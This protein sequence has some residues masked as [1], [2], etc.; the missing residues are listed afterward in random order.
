MPAPSRHWSDPFAG[1][2]ARLDERV[3]DYR[4]RA[5][6]RSFGS[7]GERVRLRMPVVVYDPHH[8]SV[9]SDVDIGEFV[10]LRASGGLVIGSR[11]LVAASAVVTTRG[12]RL[13][14]PRWMTVE[15]GPVVIEDDVW[16][17]AGA[18]VLPGVTL[19]KGSVVAAGAVVTKSV[20]SFTV[21][22]G[23]PAGIL[24]NVPKLPMEPYATPIHFTR[25]ARAALDESP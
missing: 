18:T 15:D 14:H 1:A 9:G 2:V 8:L 21:V 7:V 20:P 16:V 17:G 11:V 22:G 6:L 25:D 5:L 10:V 3:Q 24:G 19:G 13:A 23:V 4:R 12:H